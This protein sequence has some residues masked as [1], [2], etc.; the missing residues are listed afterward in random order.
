MKYHN[1]TD[2]LPEELSLRE[3]SAQSQEEQIL[4]FFKERPGREF[5]PFEV[6]EITHIS[7][8]NSVRRSIT[9]LTNDGLIMKTD[10]KRISGP[11]MQKNYTWKLPI[12]TQQIPLF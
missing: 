6:M 7:C 10:I 4:L 9:N 1:S 11:Y 8:I 2:L 12:L 3:H 5:T